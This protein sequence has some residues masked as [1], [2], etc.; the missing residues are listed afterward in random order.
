MIFTHGTIHADPHAKNIL[1]RPNPDQSLNKKYQ[2][3][4]LD[5]GLYSHI[6]TDMLYHYAKLWQS[7]LTKDV[8]AIKHYS[9]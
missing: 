9:T 4:L 2:I 7:Y 5:H 1:I 3:V 8:P 6:S